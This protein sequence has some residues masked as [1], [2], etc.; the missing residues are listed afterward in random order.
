MEAYFLKVP[1]AEKS[2]IKDT[3]SFSCLVR[4]TS[5]EGEGRC[6][7]TWQEDKRPALYDTS[8]IR[9]LSPL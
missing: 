4:V 8:F 1:E 5:S 7:L 6:V 3:N 2:K 9:A